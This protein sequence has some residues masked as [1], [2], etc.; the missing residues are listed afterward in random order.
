MHRK[1]LTA[2]F[3]LAVAIATPS[4]LMAQ[5]KVGIL[6][7]RQALEG[8]AEIKQKADRMQAK[9]QPRY[10]EL[11][12]LSQ[13]LQDI[14][15]QLQTATGQAAA[16]LQTEGQRKQREAQR[17]QEDLQ[18]DTE[19]ER[20]E[21]LQGANQ[22]LIAVVAQMAQ[23]KGLDLVVD[24]SITVYFSPALGITNDVVIAYDKAHPVSP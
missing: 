20:S 18:T 10:D 14:Q 1:R 7:A 13:E 19:Y 12:K 15:K 24:I 6:D 16:Q 4:A 2:L 8:T 5:A 17:L 11:A 21:I 23:E 22:R 3:F 9:F